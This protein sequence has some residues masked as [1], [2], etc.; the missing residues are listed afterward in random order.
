MGSNKESADDKNQEPRSRGHQDDAVYPPTRK[1]S[2]ENKGTTG[3][4]GLSWVHLR[5]AR[6]DHPRETA[7]K[8][9]TEERFG[10][11]VVVAD[12]M[13]HDK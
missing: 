2:D 10:R 9:L 6:S 12:D 7:Q 13:Q 11:R 3:R 5:E 4:A 8:S 1:A